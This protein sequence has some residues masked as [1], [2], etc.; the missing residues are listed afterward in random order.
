MYEARSRIRDGLTAMA[1]EAKVRYML[2]DCKALRSVDSYFLGALMG[3]HLILKGKGGSLILHGLEPDLK[4][5]FSRT[6]L[7]RVIRVVSEEADA[8][9]ESERRKAVA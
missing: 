1:R 2:L 8:L 6:R 3:A 9:R 5:V 4:R 7:D